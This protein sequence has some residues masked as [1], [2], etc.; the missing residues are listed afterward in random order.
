MSFLILI[1]VT[2]AS[3]LGWLRFKLRRG[4]TLL[5]ATLT[6]VGAFQVIVFLQLGYMD[7]FAPVAA[8]LSA[9]PSALCA[10]LTDWLCRRRDD[11][12]PPR[13]PHR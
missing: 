7:P 13:H 9:L 4:P 6:A 3:T 2:V 10:A 5:G 12:A 11:G 8:L 1:V